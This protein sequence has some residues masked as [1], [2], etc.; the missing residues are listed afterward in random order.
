M[1]NVAERLHA[2]IDDLDKA[3]GTLESVLQHVADA[4]PAPPLRVVLLNNTI[5]ALVSTIEEAFRNLFGEYLDILNERIESY[6]WLR[7]DLQKANLECAIELLREHKRSSDMQG[8]TSLVNVLASCLNGDQEYKFFKTELTYNR[9]NFRSAQV[10]EMSKNI[11][12]EK[13]WTRICDCTEIETYFGESDLDKRVV[14]LINAWNEVF[15]ERDKIVHRISQ[16]SG[17]GSERISET[18]RLFRMVMRRASTS[19]GSDVTLF[20]HH[21]A[22]RASAAGRGGS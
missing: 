15:D 12:M 13:L 17:W 5:V 18:I 7:P 11:G 9:G 2:V 4:K 3:L 6:L 14:K 19:L 21:N 16:A 22:R 20:I 8:A 1:S 10:T